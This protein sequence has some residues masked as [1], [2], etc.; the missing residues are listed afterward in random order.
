MYRILFL[1]CMIAKKIKIKNIHNSLID[2]RNSN[3][4]IVQVKEQSLRI[5]VIFFYY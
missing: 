5:F 2:S 1:L 4:I 3:V